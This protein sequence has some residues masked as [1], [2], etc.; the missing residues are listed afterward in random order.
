MSV[1]SRRPNRLPRQARE[2]RAFQLV[3]AGGTAGVV[4]VVTGIL[5]LVTAFTW[6]PA[7]LATIVLIACVLLF[8]RTVGS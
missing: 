3:V 5:A 8:R 7:V 6:T 2:Q 4:A 1:P